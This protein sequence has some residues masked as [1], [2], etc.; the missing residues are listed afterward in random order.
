MR[1]LGIETSCDETAAVILEIQNGRFRIVS[2]VVASSVELQAKYGGIVPEVAARKQIEFIMPVLEQV[3]NKAKGKRPPQMRGRQKAKLVDCVAVTHGPGLI[4]SLR[5]GV[6]TARTLSYI[7]KKPLIG[8][9]HLEGHIYS[10]LLSAKKNNFQIPISNFQKNPKFKIPA[11]A[12]ASAGRQNS[13]FQKLPRLTFPAMALVVSGGHTE[14]VLMRDYGK[15]KIIGQTLDDAVG[16]A[17]DKVAKILDL[18]YPGGPI[19]AR[20]ATQGDK[21]NFE[22]PRPM[23]KSG[24]YNFSFAGLKTA[25]LYK[26]KSKKSLQLDGPVKGKSM[27]VNNLCASFQEACVDVLVDKTIKAAE[28]YKVKTILL[29]GG[30]AANESLREKL[31]TEVNKV[32]LVK[33]VDKGKKII[34]LLMPELEFTGDNAAMIALAGYLQVTKAQN[35]ESTKSQKPEEKNKLLNNWKRIK[36]DPNLRL[37]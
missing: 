29:G 9:N 8:V 3:L 12:K 19:I 17:F 16:E 30:V 35:H 2:S 36:V 5:V 1:I 15:Y 24:D 14:L 7:W 27:E 13:I 28:K 34:E 21:N 26:V 23:I 31:R 4:T 37:K 22:L 6:E 32:N 25:V 11:Y 33:K 18:G 20:L 10:S